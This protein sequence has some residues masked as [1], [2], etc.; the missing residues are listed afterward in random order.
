MILLMSLVCPGC[1]YMSKSGRQQMAYQHYIRKHVRQREKALAQAQKKAKH[2]MKKNMQSLPAD[3]PQV[4]ATADR[5]E[6]MAP[7]TVSESGSPESLTGA[8]RP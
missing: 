5:M 8:P 2:Q 6:P 3:D 4:T 7:I 1:A